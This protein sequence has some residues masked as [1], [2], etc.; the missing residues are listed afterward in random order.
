MRIETIDDKSPYLAAVKALWRANASTLGFFP[1]GAFL[2]YASKRCITVALDPCGQC[3]GYLLF[4]K[5]RGQVTIVHLCTSQSHRCKGIARALVSHL[6]RSTRNL[7]GIGLWCRRDFEASRFWP[8]L[9]FVAIQDR[10]GKGREGTDLTFWWLDHGHPNLFSLPGKEHQ[11]RRLQGVVDVNVFYDFQADQCPESEESKALLADWLQEYLEVCLNEE[12]LN[13]INRIHDP[14]VRRQQRRLAETYTI[15]RCDRQAFEAAMTMT[16]R[17]FVSRTTEQDR[18]DHRQIARTIASGAKLF[19]TRDNR[20]L[21]I[22]DD[23]YEASG[24]SIVRPAEAIV[25]LDELARE[26]EYQ[27]ARLAGTRLTIG[28]ARSDRTLSLLSSWRCVVLGEKKADFGN[29]LSYYLANPDRFSSCVVTDGSGE[30]LALVVYDRAYGGHLLVPM[31]RVREGSL[32]ATITRYLLFQISTTSY[33]EG[34]TLI[35]LT[36]PYIGDSTRAALKEGGFFQV[37]HDWIKITLPVAESAQSLSQRLA[38]VLVSAE[39]DS[40][41]FTPI[42]DALRTSVV[43]RDP[44]AVSE[45]EHLLWPAKIVDADVPTY[46]VPIRPQWAQHLFEEHLAGQTLFGATPELALNRECVY[47]RARRPSGVLAPGRILWYVSKDKRYEGSGY[48][49]AC[50]RLEEVVIADPKTLYR[51]FRRLGVYTWADLLKTVHG[52]PNEAMMAIRFSDTEL[53]TKP[54]PWGLLQDFLSQEGCRSQLQSPYRISRQLF[55]ELYTLGT[56]TDSP[57]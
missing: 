22:A 16:Q 48:I 26:A 14:E 2:D 10:P 13:E 4:R 50:S 34:R 51:R 40:T 49:R 7:Q 57:R 32:S 28:R 52:D 31:F 42:T 38:A 46:V 29:R 6:S 15:L 39:L 33:R 9:G 11:T 55:K 35:R 21:G 37:G 53:F 56:S 41:C 44:E 1:D 5:S 19:I 45:V 20:L 54:I 30:P 36:D 43:M 18:S 47:Y 24:L 12:T 3:V 8:R 25:R 17:F 27:P 23:V